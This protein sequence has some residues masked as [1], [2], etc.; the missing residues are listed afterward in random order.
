MRHLHEIGMFF[1]EWLIPWIGVAAVA[2]AILGL[3]RLAVSFG[4]F[5][6]FDVFVMPWIK[7]WF[8]QLPP[9]VSIPAIVVFALLVIYALIALVFGEG[10]ASQAIGQV[11]GTWLVRLLDVM[12][13]GPFYLLRWL[14]R[15]LR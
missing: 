12:I 15:L 5:V 9:W 14:F 6:A 7:P 10:V 4:S 1:P 3:K 8:E 13:L 2:T 11:I